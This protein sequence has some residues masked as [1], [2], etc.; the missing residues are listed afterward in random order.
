M[1]YILASQPKY[2]E[3]LTALTVKMAAVWVVAQCRLV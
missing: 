1:V 3:F 2:D